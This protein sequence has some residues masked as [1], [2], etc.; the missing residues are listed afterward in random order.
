MTKKSKSSK[1]SKS[2]LKR[3]ES[4]VNRKRGTLAI[5]SIQM[6]NR[7]EVGLEDLS[8]REGFQIYGNAS[9][10]GSAVLGS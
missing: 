9:I 3:T 5:S 6:P 1:V 8:F 4:V 2:T 7:L 10:S